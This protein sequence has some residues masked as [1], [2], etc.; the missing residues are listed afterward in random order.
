MT[1]EWWDVHYVS[2]LRDRGIDTDPRV[3]GDASRG[4]V[5]GTDLNDEAQVEASFCYA[6][7]TIQSLQAQSPRTLEVLVLG[8][9]LSPL[10]FALA[11]RGNWSV[12]CLEI[13]SGLIKHLQIAAELLPRAPSFKLGD[14]T[15]VGNDTGLLGRADLV[16]DENVL[17]GMVGTASKQKGVNMQMAAINGISRLLHPGGV[18]LTLSFLPLDGDPGAAAIFDQWRRAPEL[19]VWRKMTNQTCSLPDLLLTAAIWERARTF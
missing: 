4:E 14:V 8:C 15:K 18:L 6:Q 5:F 10:V 19:E 17:D 3:S 16:I 13:S 11:D 12:T 1:Q 9:G 2:M 7:S